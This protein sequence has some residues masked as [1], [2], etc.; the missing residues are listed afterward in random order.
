MD[1]EFAEI[2]KDK[3]EYYGNT[4]AAIEF[5]AE[6]YAKQFG[7]YKS[8]YALKLGDECKYDK[9]PDMFF[10][11]RLTFNLVEGTVTADINSKFKDYKNIDAT[12]LIVLNNCKNMFCP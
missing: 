7:K 11:S 2:L 12:K 8:I 10:I 1:K 5:A 6:E 9:E 3:R 4:E